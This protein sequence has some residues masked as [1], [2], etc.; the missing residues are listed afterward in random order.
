MIDN[1]GWYPFSLDDL[2]N[3]AEAVRSSLPDECLAAAYGEDGGRVLVQ[4]IAGAL[5]AFAPHI[6]AAAL[7]DYAD[8]LYGVDEPR[9]GSAEWIQWVGAHRL[10]E[11]AS[12]MLNWRDEVDIPEQATSSPVVRSLRSA[13][14]R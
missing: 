5:V 1:A 3:A 10:R 2:R 14:A 6:G 8:E 4:A 11:H 13:S 12:R 7:L 9:S